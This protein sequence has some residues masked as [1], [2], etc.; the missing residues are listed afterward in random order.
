MFVFDILEHIAEIG[1][2]RQGYKQLNVVS[3]NKAPARLDLRSWRTD[4]N[5]VQQPNKGITLTDAEAQALYNALG[6]YLHNGQA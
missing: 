5:G 6:K 1:S 2:N 4:E 3:W